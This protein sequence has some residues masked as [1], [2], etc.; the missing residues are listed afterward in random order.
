MK[1]IK[2]Y[3]FEIL[4]IVITLTGL[5]LNIYAQVNDFGKQQRLAKA[6][7]FKSGDVVYHKILQRTC[8]VDYAVNPSMWNDEIPVYILKVPNLNRNEG[9]KFFHQLKVNEKEIE[10]DE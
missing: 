6:C 10:K 7:K 2:E 9:D 3:I 5:G 4:L 1:F 8:I